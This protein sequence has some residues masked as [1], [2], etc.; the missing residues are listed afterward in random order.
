MLLRATLAALAARPTDSDS[1]LPPPPPLPLLLLLLL[2]LPPPPSLLSLG[3][4]PASVARL[5][6]LVQR[7]K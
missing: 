7:G 2:L 3:W 5:A 6:L 1:R 4:A